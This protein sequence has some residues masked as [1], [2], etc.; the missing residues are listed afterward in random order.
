VFDVTAA[1]MSAISQRIFAGR[2]SAAAKFP[3]A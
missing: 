2:L 1:A 3:R